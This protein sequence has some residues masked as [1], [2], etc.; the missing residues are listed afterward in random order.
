MTTDIEE[1]LKE[2]G[3]AIVMTAAGKYI[4]QL[5][6]ATGFVDQAMVQDRIGS[7]MGLRWPLEYSCQLIPQ[8]VRAPNGQEMVVPVRN[9]QALPIGHCL[10]V[11]NLLIQVT[12]I[13]VIFFSK[14]SASDRRWHETLVKDGIREIIS[15]RAEAAGIL[16]P[17]VEAMSN[18]RR[19]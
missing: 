6:S 13:D 9:I 3:W 18:A 5:V 10:D 11:E 19:P 4:G 2:E 15:A 16:D 8:R 14:L 7:M 1:A 17:R 12:P